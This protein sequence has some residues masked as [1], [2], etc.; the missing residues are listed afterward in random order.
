MNAAMPLLDLE[1]RGY[2]RL[3]S[4]LSKR[5][6]RRM[7]ELGLTTVQAYLDR[8]QNDPR[9][10]AAFDALCR[11]SISRFFRDRPVF[12][13]LRDT[14]L[15]RLVA[16]A[17]RAGRQRLAA[18]SA[19]CASGEEP[20]SLAVLW[21]F[22]LQPAHPE[23]ELD[24]LATDADERLLGRA[25][26]ARYSAATLRELPPEWRELAFERDGTLLCVRE[27][28][29]RMVRF[30]ARDL[31]VSAPDEIFDLVLCRNTAFT[32]F[33]PSLQQ[34]LAERVWSI[35]AAG[36]VLLVGAHE[37]LPH[38]ASRCWANPS[39]GVYIKLPRARGLSGQREPRT[40]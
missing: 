38:S 1:P 29:R 6:A 33:R 16:D 14:H 2:R 13:Q 22:G 21:R 9:E 24:I 26:S 28:V 30:E 7:A 25:R 5:L 8:L 18:W 20:Y 27:A 31:R 34:R 39:P 40:R 19:G 23:V 12:E 17:H 3:R 35:L 36:G 15:P 4:T 11:M 32:Y 37:S 10:L